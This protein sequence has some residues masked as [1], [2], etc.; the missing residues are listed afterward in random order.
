MRVV[1]LELTNFRCFEKRKFDFAPGFNVCIGDNAT[2]K[3]ALLDALCIAVGSF[4]MGIE[5]ASGRLP[6]EDDV[7]TVTI[8]H[9]NTVTREPVRP[10]FVECKGWFRGFGPYLTRKHGTI[11]SVDEVESYWWRSLGAQRATR[12]GAVGIKYLAELARR[13]VVAG[14]AVTLPLIAFHGTGR[15]WWNLR[16]RRQTTAAAG[17][18]SRFSGYAH[19][20]DP[21]SDQK[22][23]AQWM[24]R[25]ELRQLQEGVTIAELEA[26]RNVARAAIP[27]CSDLRYLVNDDELVATMSDGEQLPVSLLSDGQRTVLGLVSDLARRAAVLNPHLG[28]EATQ[29]TPGVVLIDELDLHLHPNWQRRIVDDLRRL[30][31]EVQFVATTHSPFII[32]SL[33]ANELIDLNRKHGNYVNESIEDIAEDV[34]GVAHPQRSRHFLAM[35]DAADAYYRLLD[36]AADVT[37]PTRLGALKQRLDALSERYPSEPAYGA[38]LRAKR[39]ARRLPGDRE[40]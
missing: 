22:G 20:L 26:V 25:L 14:D 33:R 3:T 4:L 11:A 6:V 12:K 38:F 29:K 15:L 37:D 8:R 23:F 24:K 2:G 13:R 31:P 7:R 32:Q 1:S 17:P 30:F 10:L 39:L 35:M 16:D 21:A 19:C 9:N 5:R 40:A 34:M 36:E 28:V 18:A 27:G